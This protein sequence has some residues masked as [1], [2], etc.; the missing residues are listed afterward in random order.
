[1]SE[2]NWEQIPIPDTKDD[3]ELSAKEKELIRSMREKPLTP[4]EVELLKKEKGVTGSF[5][6][7][8]ID[9]IVKER[10]EN[11]SLSSG[12]KEKIKQ[13]RDK[14]KPRRLTPAEIEYIL[15]GITKMAGLDVA[16]KKM[17]ISEIKKFYREVFAHAEV[18]PSALKEVRDTIQM[19]H[20]RALIQPMEPIG[21]DTSGGICQV[22]SQIALSSHQVTGISGA[23]SGGIDALQEILSGSVVRKIRNCFVHL[24]DKLTFDEIMDKRV[25]M[26]GINMENLVIRD[27]PDLGP[28]ARL[29]KGGPPKSLRF[30]TD[31]SGE[32]GH[33]R[34]FWHDYSPLIPNEASQS[35]LCLRLHLNTDL[36]LVHRITMQDIAETISD[37]AAIGITDS[38]GKKKKYDGIMVAVISP[39]ADGIADIFPNEELLD[40]IDYSGLS[41]QEKGHNFL[42]SIAT[43]GLA[44]MH[45]KGIRGIKRIF[46]VAIPVWSAIFS[47]VKVDDPDLVRTLLK[48]PEGKKVHGIVRG[49][50]THSDEKKSIPLTSLSSLPSLPSQYVSISLPTA[51]APTPYTTVVS[52]TPFAPVVVR[53]PSLQ[54]TSTV[55]IQSPF[56]TPL[57]T[58]LPT[59]LITIQSA[60][61]SARI[62]FSTSST[63]LA[64]ST[65]AIQSPFSTSSTPLTTS[66]PTPF[67]TSTTSSTP[68]ITTSAPPSP[69]PAGWKNDFWK[70]NLNRNTMKFNGV[71]LADIKALLSA[72]RIKLLPSPP[73]TPSST[74]YVR[75]PSQWNMGTIKQ[76]EQAKKRIKENQSVE[77]KARRYRHRIGLPPK[78]VKETIGSKPLYDAPGMYIMSLVREDK[79][80]ESELIQKARADATSRGVPYIPPVYQYSKAVLASEFYFI[81]TEGSNLEAILALPWVDETRTTSNDL[82]QT[83]STL[84]VEAA[85]TAFTTELAGLIK[86]TGKYIDPRSIET[87]AD[88]MFCRGRIY[89]MNYTGF[90]NQEI[91]VFSLS[92]FERPYYVLTSGA[93]H[94]M[95]EP[96]NT[97]SAAIATNE[98]PLIGTGGITEYSSIQKQTEYL[99][100]LGRDRDQLAARGEKVDV[101]NQDFSSA[102][103]ALATSMSASGDPIDISK[104]TDSLEGMGRFM[105]NPE[106][107]NP[108]Q[109]IIQDAPEDSTPKMNFDRDLRPPKIVSGR[110]VSPTRDAIESSRMEI[111]LPDFLTSIGIDVSTIVVEDPVE[112]KGVDPSKVGGIIR[113]TEIKIELL[114]PGILSMGEIRSQLPTPLP[115]FGTGFGSILERALEAVNV[116]DIQ[117]NPVLVGDYGNMRSVSKELGLPPLTSITLR[118]E[119][120]IP[121][122]GEEDTHR[123]RVPLVD[124]STFVTTILG[125]VGTGSGSV[126]LPVVATALVQ[127]ASL[128]IPRSVGYPPPGGRGGWGQGRGRGGGRSQ[129]EFIPRTPTSRGQIWGGTIPGSSMRR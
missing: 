112:A 63:P 38:N 35:A 24:R 28:V 47:E 118:G 103:Q 116:N 89:G 8:Q 80:N 106:K 21:I 119:E 98:A 124:Y 93:S 65:V 51:T 87:C 76:R 95:W 45:V 88:F 18:C 70:L 7:D 20:E 78:K 123:P 121:L 13:E 2:Y 128:G 42:Q 26:V 17:A 30:G 129:G 105:T 40:N 100:A 44:E 41:K 50:T 113:S 72:T 102:F 25:S 29:L 23:I 69:L 11:E 22:I 10:L 82:H 58:S 99:A 43:V 64:T 104:H 110:F 120:I 86:S 71:T 94:G 14:D 117:D 90:R 62:P 114:A 61:T 16:A 1:M 9:S 84:G 12:E 54:T 34:Y 111:P 33:E 91:G 97:I 126:A 39:N 73:R 49:D 79:Q 46:P 53:A 57:T 60:G 67:S 127:P 6:K 81:M 37:N 31:L 68:L 108:N 3:R 107:F 48:K 83:A 92:T 55:A 56:S 96:T 4:E 5:T 74:I 77:E 109:G 19:Y 15:G 66:L 115:Y 36:M 75:M 125:K 85:Q 32:D 101:I 59:P 52:S 122:G 27:P